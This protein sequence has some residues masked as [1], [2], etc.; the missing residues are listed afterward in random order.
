MVLSDPGA[1]SAPLSPSPLRLRITAPAGGFF[2]GKCCLL[3]NLRAPL[4]S[5]RI[6]PGIPGVAGT[7]GG[8][9]GGSGREQALLTGRDLLGSVLQSE[10]E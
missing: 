9:D 3:P 5:S 2:F 8:L 6:D 1:P 7:G 4:K 10:K